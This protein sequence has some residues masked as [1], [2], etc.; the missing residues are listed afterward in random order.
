MEAQNFSHCAHGFRQ[1]LDFHT[2]INV[3]S[4][5]WMWSCAVIGGASAFIESTLARCSRELIAS[6]YPP[7]QPH[8]R[9]TFSL[10]FLIITMRLQYC[11]N[12]LRPLLRHTA[13][14]IRLSHRAVPFSPKP[15][16]KKAA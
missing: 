15:H 4:V 9:R 10:N 1:L 13:L 8:P 11:F 6:L 16:R 5:F 3:G 12:N 14:M 7:A 2:A